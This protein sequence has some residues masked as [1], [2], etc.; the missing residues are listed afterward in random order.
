MNWIKIIAALT[1]FGFFSNANAQVG[2]E[3]EAYKQGESIFKA[4]CASCHKINQNL[5]GPA[6]AGVY[7]KYDRDWLYEWIKNSQALVKAGDADAAKI[8][9]EYTRNCEENNKK[10]SD[11][12][13]LN[14][15]LLNS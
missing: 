1:M 5:T 6:L 9:N 8:F 11:I 14:S 3:N 12:A 10:N 7:D 13:C 4:N 2:C 15:K